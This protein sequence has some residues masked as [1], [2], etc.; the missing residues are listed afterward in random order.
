MT[1]GAGDLPDPGHV[2]A[3]LVYAMVCVRPK[4]EMGQAFTSRADREKIAVGACSRPV[5]P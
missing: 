3:K 5:H 1:A 4:F 2:P